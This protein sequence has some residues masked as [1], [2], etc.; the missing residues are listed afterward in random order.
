MSEDG[1]RLLV[2]LG[3]D[4]HQIE[5]L[6]F[7]FGMDEH[8]HV[9]LFREVGYVRQEFAPTPIGVAFLPQLFRKRLPFFIVKIEDMQTVIF[10]LNR[11]LASDIDGDVQLVAIRCMV[12]QFR[13]FRF[14]H[15][16]PTHVKHG[17][18]GCVLIAW[19]IT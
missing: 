13:D 14:Q 11:F 15:L 16:L 9:T 19:D 18:D 1:P 6:L 4:L 12:F 17:S 2:T 7:I 5:H 3:N 8:D 10:G